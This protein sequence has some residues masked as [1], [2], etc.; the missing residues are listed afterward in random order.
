MLPSA[1]AFIVATENNNK[2]RDIRLIVINATLRHF[3]LDL[4]I[5]FS[6]IFLK[7]LKVV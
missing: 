1:F 5:D 3:R 2:L 7:Q 6:H 4:I